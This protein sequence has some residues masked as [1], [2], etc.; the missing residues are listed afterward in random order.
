MPKFQE[1]SKFVPPLVAVFVLAAFLFL[2][3]VLRAEDRAQVQ[4]KIQLKAKNVKDE[5]QGRVHS[6]I[7][8]LVRMSKRW[9]NEGRTPR[10]LWEADARL[11]AEHSLMYQAI[12]WVDADYRVRWIE[13]LEGNEK[14]QDLD[15][16]FEENR[17]A[18]ME[19]AR[20]YRRAAV[21]HAVDLVQGGKGFLGFSPIFRGGEFDGFILGV[22][23][24]DHLLNA[25]LEERIAGGVTVA[26]YDEEQKI[27][28][29]GPANAPI[30]RAWTRETNI[31][32][33]GVRWHLHVWPTPEFLKE[34]R[35]ALP[36][37]VLVLGA[38]IACFMGFL[39]RLA[40]RARRYGAEVAFINIELEKEIVERQQAERR[41]QVKSDYILLLQKITDFAN[42]EQT[43]EEIVQFCLDSICQ[44]V[45]W[46][47]GHVY[48]LDKVAR[49]RLI[50]STIWHIEDSGRVQT[51]KEATEKTDFE[52]GVGMPGR[53]LAGK[54]AV[55]IMDVTR[56]GNFPR[57][58]AAV[59][60]GVRGAFGFPILVNNE[61][62][63][64]MEFFAAAPREPDEKLL[65]VMSLIGVQVGRAIERGRAE[66][67]SRESKAF[68]QAIVTHLS[69]GVVVIDEAGTV[70]EFNPSAERVFGYPADE[71][72][73]KNVN[74]LMPEPYRSEHD[75]HLKRYLQTGKSKAIGMSRELAG[76]RKDGRIFP[77]DLSV[78]ETFQGNRRLFIGTLRDI[79]ARKEM[80]GRL[81]ML[82]SAVEQSPSSIVMTDAQGKIEYVNPVFLRTTGYAL[83]EVVGQ[84]PRVIK[85]GV[86]SPEFYNSMWETIRAGIPWRGDFCNKRKNGELYWALQSISPI[87]DALG[88][89]T[90]FVCVTIDDTERKEAEKSLRES[91]E[92]LRSII[93][94]ATAAIYVK[95]IQGRFL[96]VNRRMEKLAGLTSEQIRGKTDHDLFPKE[97]ADQFTANDRTVLDTGLPLEIE[98]TLARDE[99]LHTYISTKVPLRDSAGKIYGL[100]GLSTDIT[101]RKLAEENL[102]KSNLFLSSLLDS[103]TETSIISTDMEGTVLYWNKGA[104]KMLGYRALEMMGHKHKV[105]ILY[106]DDETRRTVR[107][108]FSSIL[109]NKR[110][111]GCEIPELTKSGEIIWVK[112]TLSPK[113]DESGNVAGILGIG[114]NVTQRKL[115]EENLRASEEKSR[116]IVDT[117]SDAFVSIDEAGAITEWNAQAEKIFGWSR[118]EA[119]GRSMADLIVPQNLRE[120]HRAGVRRFL[121]TGRSDILNRRVE[122]TAVHRDGREFPVEL[123]IT[124]MRFKDKYAFN[125]FVH[126]I[127]ER[128]MMMAQLTHAQK[129]ES[130]GQLSAGIAH[131]INTP[132]QYI[133]DN[134]RFLQ[135]SFKDL[136]TALGEYGRLLENGKNGAVS[137][138]LV[139]SVEAA[140][141]GADLDYLAAEIPK[142]IDQSL[143]GVGRVTKIVRA[144]KEFSH[145]GDSEKKPSD[146]NKMLETTVTVSRNEW[147]YVSSVE[148]DLDPGLPMVPCLADD[149]NQ[150]F[151]N[152]IVNAAHAIGDVV[153]GDEANKGTITIATRRADGW[154]EVRVKDTGTGIPEEV[155]PRIFDPFFTTKEVGKGTGQGLS[156]VHAVVVKKHGGTVSFETEMGKGTTFVIRL[157]IA[158]PGED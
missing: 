94:N 102:R 18:A 141:N 1:T 5:I 100:C 89:V 53:V 83:E 3:Q 2:W 58:R 142:A 59:N 29:S 52:F 80:E 79:T 103:P 154:A 97:N 117:A 4:A 98:E 64:V 135:D 137:G 115:A 62:I 107:E 105:N 75:G 57:A 116:L 106:P 127:S 11:Y 67:S 134:L 92:R 132:M 91:E 151:L 152:V 44:T 121:E 22:F 138:K 129:M 15:L 61:V 133:G 45:G 111:V 146:I 68:V 113:L 21:S 120:A 27:Y 81:K 147:K 84:T 99:G 7:K 19:K 124:G 153:G 123:S 48:F 14:A 40:L 20:K 13:P 69:D 144:M 119:L 31:D 42:Q 125:A 33:Y 130:I 122:L 51:F 85:S 108:A 95:D 112:L 78:A 131:E 32:L 101:H 93:D 43:V 41:L 24:I 17:R 66:A 34:E 65:E 35:S 82:S 126:D 60:V 8:A 49:A 37:T 54:K 114:E 10:P 87:K 25:I 36:G 9:E 148:M 50:P 158:P 157:P 150:V 47:V 109:G 71:V 28:Q 72:I 149:M 143:E 86:H 140:V 55:W 73:G 139:E 118:R 88:R 46:P 26:L 30:E 96:L 110:G 74:M 63:A 77:L 145:P 136:L 76:I 6:E 38:L 104:E 128:K 12:E 90:H 56:D 23:R 156:I 16:A 70:T 155:R 39:A